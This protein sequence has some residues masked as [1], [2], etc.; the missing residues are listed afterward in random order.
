MKGYIVK[1]WT[2]GL[3]TFVMI[4]A[5]VTFLYTEI[6]TPAKGEQS[7]FKTAELFTSS[8][9][10]ITYLARSDSPE[11]FSLHSNLT[12]K[13]VS[14]IDEAEWLE[15]LNNTVN[16][17]TTVKNAPAIQGAYDLLLIYEN[18][19]PDQCK[20]WVHDGNVYIKKMKERRAYKMKSDQTAK[21]INR[22]EEMEELVNF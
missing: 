22:I 2:G 18:R 6:Q 19:K 10:V 14:I 15:T 3:L 17:Q 9:I 16:G 11:Q 7:V 20:L 12:R 21:F 5:C 1:N 13:G 8:S 4:L